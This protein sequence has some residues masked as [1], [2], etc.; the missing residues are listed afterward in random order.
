M[1]S[2]ES[3]ERINYLKNKRNELYIRC[4]IIVEKHII[5]FKEK[6]KKYIFI[7]YKILLIKEII[8]VSKIYNK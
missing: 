3:R 5:H 4:N 6:E 1:N 8:I 2:I 7:S